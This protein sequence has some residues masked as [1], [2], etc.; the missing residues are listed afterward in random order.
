MKRFK[1]KKFTEQELQSIN[2][3]LEVQKIGSVAEKSLDPEHFPVFEVP[4]NQKVLVYVPNHTVIDPET[5]KEVLRM[6]KPFLH[7]VVEGK[8]FSRVRCVRGLSEDAGFTGTCPFCD[9]A[10]DSWDLANEMIKEKCAAAGLNPDDKDNEAVKNIRRECYDQRVIRNT[11]QYYTFPIVVIETAPNDI[12]TAIRDEDGNIKYKVM[13]YTISKASYEKKWE[14]TLDGMEDDPEHPGGH[15]F[16]L[17]YTYTPK[18]GEPNKRDSARE[19]QV[20]PRKMKNFDQYAEFFDKATEE[21]T[22]QKCRETV[23][24]NIIVDFNELDEEAKKIIRPTRDKLELYRNLAITGESSADKGGFNFEPVAQS[25]DAG[26]ST[27]DG[28]ALETDMD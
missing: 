25:G 11:D 18:T 23:A 19:L 14:K 8:R 7:S 20:V 21:W 2:R 6:D 17:D 1:P 22:E 4:V 28:L 27:S 13:W 12:K 26:L 15:V 24:D 16:I 9:A 5:K 3:D 10:G